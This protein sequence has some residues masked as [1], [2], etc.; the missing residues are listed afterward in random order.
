MAGEGL[1][2]AGRHLWVLSHLSKMLKK[3]K[4]I[5]KITIFRYKAI[6]AT[7]LLRFI[8]EKNTVDFCFIVFTD[9]WACP[10]LWGV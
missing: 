3:I 9:G 10:K 5:L 4:N 1:S 6:L 7:K 8:H 2:L